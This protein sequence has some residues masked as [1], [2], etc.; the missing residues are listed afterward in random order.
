MMRDR[1]KRERMKDE[2]AQLFTMIDCM[3]LRSNLHDG[4]D[5]NVCITTLELRKSRGLM[6]LCNANVIM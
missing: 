1:E 4:I 2:E 5:E 6:W 3:P